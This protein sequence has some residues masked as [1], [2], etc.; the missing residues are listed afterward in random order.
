VICGR[1]ADARPGPGIDKGVEYA[2]NTSATDSIALLNRLTLVD[3][4]GSGAL[5]AISVLMGP[6]GRGCALQLQSLVSVGQWGWKVA[7]AE[8]RRR[9]CAVVL[10]IAVV[11]CS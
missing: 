2:L 5:F 7:R 11:T 3:M 4:A 10:R 9:R 1:F 6:V 8:R